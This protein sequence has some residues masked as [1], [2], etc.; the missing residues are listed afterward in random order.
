MNELENLVEETVEDVASGKNVGEIVARVVTGITCFTIGVVV[1]KWNDI[2]AWG[3]AKRE[4][5]LEKKA[6][7]LAAKEAEELED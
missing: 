5:R 1:G 4:A 3:A 6:A 7:K 2:R